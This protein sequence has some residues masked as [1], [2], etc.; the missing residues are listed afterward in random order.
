V[1]I[2]AVRAFYL[3]TVDDSFGAPGV[4]RAHWGALNYLTLWSGAALAPTA[5]ADVRLS[6]E[7]AS[8]PDLV[9]NTFGLTFV[10]SRL[11]ECV[12]PLLQPTDEVLPAPFVD[13]TTGDP[14]SGYFLLR[15]TCLLDALAEP[16]ASVSDLRIDPAKVPDGT[17][18]FR[19]AQ[20]KTVTLVSQVFL[21][22]ISG[23]GLNGIALLRTTVV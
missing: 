11:L 12:R 13:S 1:R 4:A 5:L 21:D 19:L 20:H 9:P 15:T 10:S 7:A 2:S 3:L 8:G 23:R 17:H 22:R 18:L 14:V 16:L 6:I